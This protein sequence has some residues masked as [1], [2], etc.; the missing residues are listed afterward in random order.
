MTVGTRKTVLT[1]ISNRT[2]GQIRQAPILSDGMKISQILI[3]SDSF[4][5]N[6][7]KSGFIT[8][9]KPLLFTGITSCIPL[10]PCIE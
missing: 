2:Q 8:D 9:K 6:G 5:Y 3:G 10:K 1:K 4:K 7:Y